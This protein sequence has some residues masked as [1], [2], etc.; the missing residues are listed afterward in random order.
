MLHIGRG[1]AIE[2]HWAQGHNDR[3]PALAADLVR[4]QVVAI[5]AR[6]CGEIANAPELA[7][8]L[9]PHKERPDNRCAGSSWVNEQIAFFVGIAPRSSDRQ[10]GAG[11]AGAGPNRLLDAAAWMITAASSG[12][13]NPRAKRSCAATRTR[14]T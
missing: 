13:R 2:F 1:A 8:V 6:H 11:F 3:L 4:R 7:G 10:R 5:F 9:G 14:F 12:S